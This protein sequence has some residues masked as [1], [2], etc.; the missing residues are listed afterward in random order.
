M[1]LLSILLHRPAFLSLPLF[2]FLFSFFLSLCLFCLWPRPSAPPIKL[3][4]K[5]TQER[6]QR[7]TPPAQCQLLTV[8]VY[9]RPPG[10]SLAS[11][12]TVRRAGARRRSSCAQHSPLRPAPTTTTSTSAAAAILKFK[13]RGKKLRRRR[14]RRRRREERE[15]DQKRETKNKQQRESKVNM[16]K[17]NSARIARVGGKDASTLHTHNAKLVAPAKIEIES[18]SSSSFL[19]VLFPSH[20]PRPVVVDQVWSGHGGHGSLPGPCLP[21]RAAHGAPAGPAPWAAR[22]GGNPPSA[23]AS[24][25]CVGVSWARRRRLYCSVAAAW[26]APRGRGGAEHGCPPCPRRGRARRLSHGCTAPLSWIAR[27]QMSLSP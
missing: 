2:F 27:H 1:L 12:T 14:R 26:P 24:A 11:S 20:F 8:V 22:R 6:G 25:D 13:K 19:L 4:S 23:R 3:I 16:N 5:I 17:Y 21:V 18:S 9:S 7:A 15:R 10:R